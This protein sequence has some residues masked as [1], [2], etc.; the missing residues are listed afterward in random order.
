MQNLAIA[1]CDELGGEFCITNYP[2][3][4][5]CMLMSIL[6]WVDIIK[7]GKQEIFL[8]TTV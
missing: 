1:I 8:V 5:T 2:G 3:M 7:N 6:Y 4:R